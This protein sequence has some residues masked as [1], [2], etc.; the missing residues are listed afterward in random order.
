[1][2]HDDRYLK[3]LIKHE[4]LR[5]KPYLDTAKPKPKLTIGIGRNLDDKGLSVPECVFLGNNDL[6]E[7]STELARVF[8]G[9]EFDAARHAALVDMMV[10]LGLPRFLG[11]KRMIAAVKR[12]DWH[13]AAD[14]ML[15]S[16]WHRE[17]VGQRAKDLA[18]MVRSGIWLPL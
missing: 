15:D 9:M 7:G 6:A 2:T 16:K 13:K 8:P 1:M 18:A 11:F 14:E 5:T 12:R 4:G 3:L 10:N 17:D